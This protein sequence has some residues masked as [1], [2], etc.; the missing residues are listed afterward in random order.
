MEEEKGRGNES[1]LG[2]YKKW[3]SISLSLPVFSKGHEA[4][5]EGRKLYGQY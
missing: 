5:G 4:S 3:R 1:G 2:D